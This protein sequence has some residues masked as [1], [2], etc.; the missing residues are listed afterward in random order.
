LLRQVLRLNFDLKFVAWHV[1][2]FGLSRKPC[3]R[4]EIIAP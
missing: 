1:C 2:D 4:G 3:R